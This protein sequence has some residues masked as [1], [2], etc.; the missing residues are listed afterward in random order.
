MPLGG[1]CGLHRNH[2]AMRL[3]LAKSCMC[4]VHRAVSSSGDCVPRAVG[5]QE[6][7]RLRAQHSDLRR[8]E[9]V[10]KN[11]GLLG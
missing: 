10:T 11:V 3:A 5:E 1:S 4:E 2:G 9:Q 8:A 7:Q 6:V